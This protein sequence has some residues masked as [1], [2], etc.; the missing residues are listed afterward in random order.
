MMVMVPTMP[1]KLFDR[2]LGA[3]CHSAR[4]RY[5]IP[6]SSRIVRVICVAL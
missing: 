6:V 3:A 1:V 2:A 5:A 4:K